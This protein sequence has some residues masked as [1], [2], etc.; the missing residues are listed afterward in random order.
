MPNWVML[1]MNCILNFVFFMIGFDSSSVYSNL[2]NVYFLYYSWIELRSCKLLNNNK[3]MFYKPI[4]IRWFTKTALRLREGY[5]F[6][7]KKSLLKRYCFV[8]KKYFFSSYRNKIFEN[9]I[10]NI[11]LPFFSFYFNYQKASLL[12]KLCFRI[13]GVI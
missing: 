9:A 3:L 4:S 1:I 13:Y 11:I 5:S 6:Y 7:G 2:F 8:N 12:K 10:F